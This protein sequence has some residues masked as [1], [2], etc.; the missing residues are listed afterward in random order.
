MT[1][2]GFLARALVALAIV[3]AG[4]VVSRAAGGDGAAP[5]AEVAAAGAGDAAPVKAE[6]RVAELAPI[7]TLGPDDQRL[8][9]VD[10]GD[11]WSMHAESVVASVLFQSWHEAGGPEVL[12]KAAL[13]YP[14]TLSL[15][16]V[17]TERIIERILEGWSYTL[18]YDGS[19]RLELIRVYSPEPS[20]NFKTPRLVESLAAW[21]QLEVPPPPASPPQPEANVAPAEESAPADGDAPPDAAAPSPAPDAGD[22]PDDHSS[23]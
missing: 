13:D 21:K 17:K 5:A 19:G 16:R 23:R 7:R 6:P 22:Q 12:S 20:R 9:V 14:F 4:A 18:H 15:H 8:Y 10:H 3:A 2:P 11:T 1:A